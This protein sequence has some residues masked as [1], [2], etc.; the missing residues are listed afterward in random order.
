MKK[1]R[2]M[3]IVLMLLWAAAFLCQMPATYAEEAP[4]R[5]RYDFA[6]D[7]EGLGE[8]QMTFEVDHP[9]GTEYRICYGTADGIL[10]DYD[11]L[12]VVSPDFEQGTAAYKY[13]FPEMAAIPQKATRIFA[14]SEDETLAYRIPWEKRI[15]SEKLYSFGL[16]SDTHIVGHDG[17]NGT[18]DWYD[19]MD[20]RSCED[21]VRAIEYFNRKGTAFNIIAGDITDDG[22]ACD[23][24]KYAE[25]KRLSNAPVY[26][27]AGNHDWM[28]DGGAD[29][30]LW[31]R[32]VEP[33]GLYF[34]VEHGDDVYIFISVINTACDLTEEAVSFLEK[35]LREHADQ[36]VFI[37][38]HAYV[39]SVGNA[40]ELDTYGDREVKHEGFRALLKEY[41][42]ATLITGHSHLHFDLQF[43]ADTA[44]CAWATEELCHRIHVPSLSRPRIKADDS[45][46][47]LNNYPGSLGCIVEIYEDCAVVCGIDFENC[48]DGE[49]RLLPYAQYLIPFTPAKR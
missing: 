43:L 42:G 20:T 7:G 22:Y 21:Y 4:V 2:I 9:D 29:P 39:G 10:E 23:F 30:S 3:C 18:E 14:V 24:W 17:S 27:V 45:N 5:L 47:I 12:F 15:K 26:H 46:Q 35:E 16:M 25:L 33:N 6:S 34:S 8:G 36:R 40:C 31:T 19:E 28:R 37:V 1:K 49:G 32:Y 38:E 41:S 13:R 11:P 44:N 48:E